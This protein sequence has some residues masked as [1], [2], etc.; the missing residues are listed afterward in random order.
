MT[1]LISRS[2]IFL[3][4]ALASYACEN[5]DA[6]QA[7]Q[8]NQTTFQVRKMHYPLWVRNT[9][10]LEI[11]VSKFT[12]EGTF[13]AIRQHLPRLKKMGIGTISF[14]PIY[15][16]SISEGP[17][18][19]PNSRRVVD[20][21]KVNPDLG[22]FEDFRDL[23]TQIHQMSMHTILHWVSNHTA[24]DHAWVD[25]HPEWY[26]THP[27]KRSPALHEETNAPGVALLDYSVG[28]LRNTMIESMKFWLRAGDVDGFICDDASL[29]PDDFWNDARPA[30][31]QVKPVFMIADSEKNASHFETCFQANYAHEFSEHL[32]NIAKG[33]SSLA[34]LDEIIA[35]N[36]ATSPA[37]YYQVNLIG[38]LKVDG[39]SDNPDINVALDIIAFT[40]E[41]IPLIYN[42]TAF[43]LFTRE[44]F[45]TKLVQLK[46]F[47]KSLWNGSYGG[48]MQRINAGD[49]IYAYSR[50]KDGHRVVVI[51]NCSNQPATDTL[52]EDVFAMSALF[53]KDDLNIVIGTP[54]K[55]SPWEHWL[56]ANPSI[57][58]N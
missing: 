10:I 1:H 7:A 19:M 57:E 54:V 53:G 21:T 44:D 18:D 35:K 24:P 16:L 58:T 23:T 29:V 55:L 33:Q 56:F 5:E 25:T 14:L 22:T 30:L 45:Y 34:A 9:S 31:E 39:E 12:P 17:N 51:V 37:G 42:A 3:V 28:P 2:I 43:E 6:S 47:N 49:K 26:K 27:D 40:Q 4:L 52:T 46:N 15:P 36:R 20:F 48:T 13:N 8:S 41:G 11:D 50:A 32:A 38:N